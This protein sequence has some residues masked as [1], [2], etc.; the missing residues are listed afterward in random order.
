M[1]ITEKIRKFLDSSP[2]PLIAILGATATG[3][4]NLALSIA[5]KF[6]GEIISTDSRQIYSEM[7]I[8]TDVILPEEQKG[9]PHHMLEISPPNKTLTLAEFTELTK[10]K[11][12]EIHK[13]SC[14]P[15]LVGGTGLY[16]SAVTEEYDVPKVAPNP[17]LRAQLEKE[18]TEHGN[19][20][21]HN[22]LRELDP[23]AA[24]NIHPNNRRYVIRAIEIN[25]ETGEKK[26]SSKGK[27]QYDT[28]L[29]GI[30]R[31]RE[32]I[33][34]RINDRVDVQ[35]ERGLLEEVQALLDKGYDETLPS[36][37]SLGVKE[38]IPYLRG[39]MTLEECKEILK[40]NTR[41]YAKRQLTWLKRYDNV[42]W[43]KPEDIK[44]L[45]SE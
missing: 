18:A 7:P 22:K 45:T 37:T 20:Y 44:E 14:L 34:Q 21:I 26:Q 38:I 5:K 41:K 4:T 35:V 24:L 17:A 3:K 2:K 15:M 13:R 36:M 10:Q 8:A 32:E 27:S 1:D 40:R 25:T 30:T 43:L 23:E 28:L 16:I 42:L 29:L 19:E 12:D 11:I 33:Y 39:E 6:S 31:D 9:I